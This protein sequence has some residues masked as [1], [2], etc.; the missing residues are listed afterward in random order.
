MKS[1]ISFIRE[2][3]N[4]SPEN[5]TQ[6]TQRGNTGKT[7]EKSGQLL[8]GVLPSKSKVISVGAGLDPTGEGLRAGLGEGHVVHEM[9]PNPSGRKVQPEYTDASQIP[10]DGYDAAVCHNV[11]NVVEP[12]IRDHVMHSIF[13]S[14]KEGGHAI[15]GARKF[16]GDVGNA[17]GT[18]GEER[19]S[20]WIKKGATQS[21]QKGFDGNELAD[22]VKRFAE[23]HGHQVE[24]RRIPISA[25]GVHVRIIKKTPRD[26]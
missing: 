3:N 9:E 24:V 15:I 2:N 20:I 4:Q 6:S 5:N 16:T 23:R 8:R 19:G 25:N 22:Y 13:D 12:H 17:K 21:Y 7:Y 1:F 11:L 14:V 26:K 10:R 18:P